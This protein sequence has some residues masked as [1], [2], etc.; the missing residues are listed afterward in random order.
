MQAV[1]VG[2]AKFIPYDF[3]MTLTPYAHYS[4]SGRIL[5]SVAST[6]RPQYYKL[7]VQRNY[8]YSLKTIPSSQLR[9]PDPSTASDIS[10]TSGTI[11]L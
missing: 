7:F 4:I 9:S 3:F 6:F 1:S 5:I 8:F 2:S 11:R 10:V